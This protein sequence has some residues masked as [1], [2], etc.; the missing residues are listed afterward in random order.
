MQRPNYAHRIAKEYDGILPHHEVFY[1]R[2]IL[3]ASGNALSAFGRYHES[4][5]QKEDESRTA[6]IIFNLQDALGHCAAT[7]RYFWPSSDEK[8]AVARGKNLCRVFK[9]DESNPLFTVRH[10]R[11][12]FE[13]YDE[14]LD[15]FCARDPVGEIFD[16][17][18][19]SRALADA[20]VTHVLRLLDPLSQTVVLFGRAFSFQGLQESIQH[21]HERAV[22]MDGS[23]GRLKSYQA[24]P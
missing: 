9:L 3:F 8:L 17:I 5:M 2:S 19:E 6:A 1:I 20:E 14:K 21:I 24:G 23:G 18:I 16:L 11:N 12:I 10:I 7:S 22:S 4:L 13:H 15:R